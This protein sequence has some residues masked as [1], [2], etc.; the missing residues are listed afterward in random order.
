M[1]RKAQLPVIGG[2]R[3]V[4][5]IPG[6][7]VAVG[8]TI[9]EVG[10]GTITLAQLSAAITNVQQQ[11]QNTGGGNIGDGTEAVLKVGPGLSGGGPMLGTVLLNL[12][13]PIPWGLD[14]GGGGGDGDSGPPGQSGKAGANGATGGVGPAGPAIFM[15][16]EDGQDGQ[17]AIPGNRGANGANGATGGLGPIGPAVFFL[18]DDGDEGPMGNPGPAGVP[19]TAGTTAFS[20]VSVGMSVDA[21]VS[22]GALPFDT[23]NYDTSGYHSN[24]VNNSRLTVPATGYYHVTGNARNNSGS[25]IF[26]YW[27]LM[28]NG[29]NVVTPASPATSNT[30]GSTIVIAWEGHLNIGD[31][32]EMGLFSALGTPITVDH[33]Q[34]VFTMSFRGS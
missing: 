7:N 8:T 16:A 12:T 9:A 26:I 29:S 32:V 4:I 10:S 23:T 18:A 14:D 13:A 22:A 19:G 33:T 31:Y 2:I 17:D 25:A 20:G 30:D 28:V 6:T 1:V 15:A 27:P 21:N 24:S 34:T 5:T 11:Q 3:K